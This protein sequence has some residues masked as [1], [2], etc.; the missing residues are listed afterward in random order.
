MK[1]WNMIRRC[2]LA[3]PFILVTPFLFGQIPELDSLEKTLQNYPAQDTIRVN[4]LN[5][6]ALKV[7]R[8]D[9]EKTYRYSRQASV[10]ADSLG[11][12]KGK[13]DGLRL[14]GE[15]Y[16]RKAIPVVDT[17]KFH[18]S[19]ALELFESIDDKQGMGLT[20]R[21]LGTCYFYLNDFYQSLQY[22]HQSLRIFEELDEKEEIA[23]ILTNIGSLHSIIYNSAEALDYY[24]RALTIFEELGIKFKL[25]VCLFN[26]ADLHIKM[27]N[28]QDAQTNL[29]GSMVILEELNLKTMIPGALNNLG[30]IKKLQKDY[31]A[32]LGHYNNSLKQSEIL[33]LSG[34][35]CDNMIGLA[36]V[37]YELKNYEPAK[38]FAMKGLAI[39]NE[40]GILERQK[41]AN[42]ILPKIYEAQGDYQK[43]YQYH[44]RFKLLSD[45]LLDEESIK[46]LAGVEYQYKFDQETQALKL[47]Q[48]RKNVKQAQQ[49][50]KQEAVRKT[51]I[52]G[53]I[54]VILLVAVVMYS[55][56][57]KR[58]A[59][60]ILTEQKEAIDAQAEELKLNN[61]KLT[62]LNKSKD[63]IFSI[64]AH[65]LRSPVG[66]I[67][68]FIELILSNQKNYNQK[69]I[70]SIL[71][72]LGE[73]SASVFNI[74]E[75]LFAWA[76]SQRQNI[77]L[78]KAS[79][80]I[81]AA[82]VPTITLL[83]DSAKSK[84]IT[85]INKT[86]SSISASY[87]LTLISTVVRNL[88]ANA[89]KFT[90]ENGKIIIDVVAE[91]GQIITSIED[92]GVG[93]DPDK[94]QSLFDA[95][96]F[97]TS[98]GTNSERGSGLGLKLCYEFVTKHNGRIWVESKEGEGST[99]IFTLPID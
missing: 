37:H 58:K 61:Q 73:Q 27:G 19:E 87:D 12:S 70:M 84:K 35:I 79:Q 9:L 83:N 92:D 82:I 40:S 89:I 95:D 10:L 20:F 66:N 36:E 42:A 50:R 13:A 39:A 81:S 71:T 55:L 67:K 51:L 11:Y 68:A 15:Y 4:L 6:I 76:N 86:D 53:F 3:L 45:S 91:E 90:N 74:L 75:N 32:A 54:M 17:A 96:T 97:E 47:A 93:I 62:A 38:E 78:N 5:E 49:F 98:L 2:L 14:L 28:Y 24:S 88:L 59:N 65:D 7:N 29:E 57:Q 56:I 72:R 26:I 18:L 34:N 30:N 60:R 22:S 48:H 52:F 44:K 8:Y 43:A 85:I 94:A 63:D 23:N 64:I 25:A 46:K 80:P 33:G 31:A 41:L 99:F 77:V 16:M 21:S 1:L 69:E